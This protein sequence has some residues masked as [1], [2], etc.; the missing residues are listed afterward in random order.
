MKKM[1][2]NKILPF[3]C[4]VALVA[5]LAGIGL[6]DT[7]LGQKAQR[8][9]R[10]YFYSA[11]RYEGTDYS[12]VV[13]AIDAKSFK[14]LSEEEKLKEYREFNWPWPPSL[15]AALVDKLAEYGADRIGFDL[16]LSE[17]FEKAY[18][19]QYA[20][21]STLIDARKKHDIP[22]AL[23]AMREGGIITQPLEIYRDNGFITG[24]VNVPAVAGGEV[25]HYRFKLGD[26]DSFALALTRS[27]GGREDLLHLGWTPDVLGKKHLIDYRSPSCS[28]FPCVSYSDVL[29]GHL[30]DSMKKRW[31]IK[32]AAEL[33]NGKAVLVG[34]TSLDSHDIHSTPM[35]LLS[36]VEIQAH[37]LQMLYENRNKCP[38][39]VS[40][41]AR[42]G[43]V[44]CA[45]I[46]GVFLSLLRPGIA[47]VSSILLAT[48]YFVGAVY[49]FARF[50]VLL[51]VFEV[52][53]SY[54]FFM[55]LAGAILVFKAGRPGHVGDK[56]DRIW[57]NELDTLSLHRD[58]M[59]DINMQI[60]EEL[61]RLLKTSDGGSVLVIARIII[62]KV[63]SEVC[64]KKLGRDRGT[65]PLDGILDRL[66][67]AEIPTKNTV[68]LK[69]VVMIDDYHP[70]TLITRKIAD[71][72]LCKG[73]KRVKVKEIVP[74]NIVSS[75]RNVKELG[76]LAAHGKKFKQAQVK[77]AL[78]SLSMILNWY[79]EE[80]SKK[81]L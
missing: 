62:E 75:M 50:K 37:A 57:E 11:T 56:E 4:V 17:S 48:V 28:A 78:A 73:H 30:P 41:L 1:A 24:L 40:R 22:I 26:S 8:G 5:C 53:F 27:D 67:K 74:A 79:I 52:G 44:V 59:P 39:E 76:N 71:D 80:K 64:N 61:D 13:V 35:G 69:L 60:K 15:H 42:S 81:N 47:L 34:R 77:D 63:V 12:V 38:F 33:F 20:S 29:L 18:L 7:V 58:R 43:L 10:R 49:T 9:I 25:W 16:L 23:A 21:P 31:N 55:V 14:A 70:E 2:R 19:P 51:P 68:G 72:I 32:S 3:L 6:G 65:E 54:C 45:I 46:A 66:L 36:G